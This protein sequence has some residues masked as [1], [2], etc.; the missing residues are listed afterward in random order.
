MC[1]FDG[2]FRAKR[3]F[4]QVKLSVV[5]ISWQLTIML[6]SICTLQYSTQYIRQFNCFV[7]PFLTLIRH[8]KHQN[9]LRTTL[10]CALDSRIIFNTLFTTTQRSKTSKQSGSKLSIRSACLFC[11]KL[12]SKLGSISR[13]FL[14][15]PRHPKHLNHLAACYHDDRHKMRNIIQS[16]SRPFLC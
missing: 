1:L 7:V 14:L 13:P 5:V 10:H 2:V 15:L 4:K 16:L 9:R 6:V 11:S 3:R 12:H 8:E